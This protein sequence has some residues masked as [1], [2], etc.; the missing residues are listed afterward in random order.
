MAIREYTSA[1]KSFTFSGFLVPAEERRNKTGT[2]LEKR[3]Y[4]YYSQNSTETA[5]EEEERLPRELQSFKIRFPRRRGSRK[6]GR[7]LL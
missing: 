2:R 7:A 3:S 5:A 4:K 1:L 6:G